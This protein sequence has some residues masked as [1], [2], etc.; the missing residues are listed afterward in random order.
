VQHRSLRARNE[1]LIA[2]FISVFGFVIVSMSCQPIWS[3]K[4]DKINQ[5]P[6]P[7]VSN[8]CINVS[9]GARDEVITE[10]LRGIIQSK[11]GKGLFL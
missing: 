8:V 1:S 10:V 9:K 6:N 3:K 7:E 5:L 4:Y 11:Y 2:A